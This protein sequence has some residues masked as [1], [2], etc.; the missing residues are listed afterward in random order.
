MRVAKATLIFFSKN[1]SVFAIFNNQSFN[2]TL[3]NDIVNFEQMGPG[4][5]FSPR[6]HMLWVLIRRALLR[7]GEIKNL[8]SFGL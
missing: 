8:S 6:K 1:I 7:N 3:T 4:K 5:Y 2:D